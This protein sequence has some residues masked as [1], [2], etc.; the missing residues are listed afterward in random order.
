MDSREREMVVRRERDIERAIHMRRAH[1]GNA[2]IWCKIT[3]IFKSL[4]KGHILM[5][6]K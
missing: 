2:D 6:L 3:A 1:E 4:D 5:I